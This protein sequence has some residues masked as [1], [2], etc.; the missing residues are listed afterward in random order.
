MI[1]FLTDF[2]RNLPCMRK[3]MVFDQIYQ[4]ILRAYVNI[5]SKNFQIKMPKIE[6]LITKCRSFEKNLILLFIIIPLWLA[7]LTGCQAN[8][9]CLEPSITYTQPPCFIKS[10]P[11]PFPELIREEYLRDWGKEL[12]IANAFANELDFYRAITG[13]KRALILI[14]DKLEARRTQI[15]YHIMQ[16]YYIAGKY[17]EVLDT[18]EGSTLLCFLPNEFPA[19]NDLLTMLYDSYQQTGQYEKSCHILGIIETK[20]VVKAGRL[21]L[22]DDIV[23]GNLCGLKNYIAHENH[24]EPFCEFLNT[25]ST[26]ALSVRKAQVLNALFPGAGYLYVGQKQTALTSFCINTLFIAAAYYFF[27]HGNIAA[28]IIIT[29]LEMG[30]YIGGINGAGLAAKEYNQRIYDVMGKEIMLKEKLFP[31]LSLQYGF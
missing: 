10:L 14:P 17:Q 23:E 7:I 13:Y 21:E 2:S 20:D 8:S 4:K 24:A 28:G 5:C 29:S 22:G 1:F 31:I 15:E 3:F 30:W 18:F 12:I 26:C 11:S 9:L 16:C 19:Y 27:D 6:I 25:Y